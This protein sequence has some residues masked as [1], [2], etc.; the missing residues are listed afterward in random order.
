[1][2]VCPEHRLVLLLPWKTASQTLRARLRHLDRSPYPDFFHF[3]PR[4]KRVVHQHLTLADFLMLPESRLGYRL[5]VFV[6]NPYDRVVSGFR[7]VLRDVMSQ[8]QRRFPALWIRDLVT[9][10]LGDNFALL[11]KAQFQV[12]PWFLQLPAHE[13]LEAG[14]DTSLPLHP[15][16]YWTHADGRLV[17]DFVGRVEHFER[18]FAALCRGA[19][20]EDPGVESVNASE[21]ASAVADADGYRH[22][23]GLHPRTIARI[24]ELFR[25]DFELLGYRKLATETG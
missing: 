25:A 11:S 17:A 23:G 19:G 7:Q 8:P 1:M 24:N 9:Q 12:D 15:A 3:N 18:D 5:A 14:R 16:H 6:R 2:I 4:L 10:Q 13:I 20:I 22:A 21:D